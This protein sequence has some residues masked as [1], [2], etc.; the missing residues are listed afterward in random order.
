MNDSNKPPPLLRALQ[1]SIVVLRW[2]LLLFLLI[3]RTSKFRIVGPNESGLVLRLGRLTERVHSPGILLALPPPIDEV[4]VVPTRS[5]F[6]IELDEWVAGARDSGSG[7]DL[8]SGGGDEPP[9]MMSDPLDGG[10][11]E[12]PDTM[13]GSLDGGGDEPPV[14]MFDSLDGGGPPPIGEDM[15]HPVRDGYGLTGDVNLIHARFSVSYSISDPRA[16]VLNARDPEKVLRPLLLQAAGFVTSRMSVDDILTSGRDRFQTD[17]QKFAQQRIDQL[18]LGITLRAWET[19]DLAPANQVLSAFEEVTSA[20]V[21]AQT[22]TEQAHTYR[23]TTMPQAKADAYRTA[24]DATA[25][26]LSQIAN[27]KGTAAA[28]LAKLEAAREAPH[29]F[30]TQ[31]FHETLEDV[32]EKTRVPAIDATR[33][34]G[35]RI[36]MGGMQ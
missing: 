13:S 11:D 3:Y 31:Q 25:D 4:F 7:E 26:A 28:F 35:V 1:S 36:L 16:Y 29:A 5:V 20:K 12:P 6:E 22:W 17:C 27:A 14:T 30:R 9:V 21:E 15:L 18:G 24:Q 32:L 8:A 2:L 33:K 34:K 19:R 10:G 23:Q